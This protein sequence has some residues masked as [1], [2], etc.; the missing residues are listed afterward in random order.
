MIRLILCLVIFWNVENYFDPFDDPVTSDNDFTI[1]GAYSWTWP[2]FYKKRNDIVK[3]LIACGQQEDGSWQAPC[4]IGLC[5]IENFFV[6]YQLIND[7]PLSRLGYGIIHRDSPDPRGIDVGLLYRR[8]RFRPA[9]TAF[10]RIPAQDS[11]L[12]GTREILYVRGVLDQRDTLHFF[13]NH[14]PSRRGGAQAETNRQAASTLLQRIVDSIGKSSPGARIVVMG[15]FNDPPQAPALLSLASGRLVNVSA[16]DTYKYNG[17]W[18]CMDQ[19]LVSE[20]L[21]RELEY[22]KVARLPHLLE[23]DQTHLGHKPKRTYQGPA[24]KG[25]ISDHLPITL[26]FIT[27]VSYGISTRKDTPDGSVLCH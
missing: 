9:A 4:I 25:G 15:D 24:Y 22:V 5:E 1:K 8:E 7:T 27:F 13:V 10:Y 2:R 11:S 19:F 21:Y 6:L 16:P 18:E 26:K 3:T 20:T 17:A 23:R 14:W 12:L